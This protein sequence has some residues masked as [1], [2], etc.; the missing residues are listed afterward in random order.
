MTNKGAGVL[1]VVSG[2]SGVGK[3]TV[4]AGVLAAHPEVRRSISCA[5]RPRRPGEQDGQ[6]YYFIS[7]KEFERKQQAGEFLEWATV[8]K[9]LKYGT[10][11]RPVEEALQAGQDIIL[12]IDYQGA[13]AVR[14]QL[15]EK[16]V[17]VFIA[18]PSWEALLERLQKRHTESQEAIEK[19]LASAR[20]EIANI[21]MYEYVIIN[22]ELP[23]AIRA[24]EAVLIA[25]RHRRQ[26]SDW[27]R[28][29][30]RLGEEADAHP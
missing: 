23:E 24:L 30:Q 25:E 21:Q 7:P 1:L 15:G 27:Q 17:L 12:E 5:T 16:A 13:R 18:P 14:E 4:I 2:P 28:L 19:R 29:Q 11:R 3:G 6:D 8:H 9:D 22:D 20:R 26:R 10:P